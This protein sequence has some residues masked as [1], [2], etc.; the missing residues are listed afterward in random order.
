MKR[1]PQCGRE[2][3]NSMMFCLDDGVE[4][5]YGPAAAD[6][7]PTAILSS[8]DSSDDALTRAQVSTTNESAVFHTAGDKP[9]PQNRP[10]NNAF[11]AGVI[12]ILL[13]SLLGT[14]S[15]LYYS[16]G[17][18]KQFESIA[19]MPFVN[20][21]GNLDLEYLADGMTE[22]LIGSLSQLRNL[23]VKPRSSVFRYKGKDVDPKAIGS[24]LNVQ[25]I[26]NG[27]VVQRGQDLLLFVELVD[28]KLDKV[29]WSQRYDRSQNAIVSLQ[30]EITHDVAENLKF[31]LSSADRLRITKNSTA[32]NEAYQL[33]L[34]GRYHIQRSLKGETQEGINYLLKAI[35]LDPSYALAYA[36]LS[37]S[38]RTLSIGGELPSSEFALKS[39][40]AA[41]KAVEL[42]DGLAEGHAALGSALFFFEWDWRAAETQFQRA[43]ELDPKAGDSHQA[44]A[45]LLSS[46]GRHDEAIAEIS[47]A[48]EL[49]P[50]N[51][52]TNALEGQY[53]LHAGR[54][55]DALLQLRKTF[56]I[57]STF[58]LAHLFAA[59]AYI[60]KGMYSDAVA[61]ARRAQELTDASTHPSAFLAY[62]L[63]KSG[64]ALEARD[65][66]D[67]LLKL[68][69]ESYV[70]PYSIALIYN[71]M[72]DTDESIKWLERGYRERSPLMVFLKSE[73]KWSNLRTDPRFDSLMKR[74]GFSQ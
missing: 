42:D 18:S 20:D 48:R 59:S 11:I 73:P 39:K 49:E 67:K 64:K 51:P 34:K 21:G 61:E 8:G 30:A 24:E 33:Y 16:R 57:N 47:L 22:T 41:S 72:G 25:A 27:R 71:G 32:N 12:G 46:V 6:E 19:V 3:D 54:T 66:L 4:L 70:S 31:Q 45:A 62:A 13:V 65:V 53:L 52:R 29:V 69:G 68:S 35:D 2:Y 44:Y 56:E 14:S 10:R 55:D 36:G 43:I 74:I 50:L 23:T 60:E 15:Y 28:V 7:P 37:D 58:W 40:T 5:L 26:L 9:S 17:A 63:V 1:C 38:Y